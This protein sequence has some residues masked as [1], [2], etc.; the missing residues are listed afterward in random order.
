MTRLRGYVQV[1]LP[2]AVIVA[3]YVWACVAIYRYRADE[4]PADAIVLRFAHWQLE[5]GVRAAIDAA[6]RDYQRSVNPRVRVIQNIIPEST[7]AQWVSTQ[8]MGG[9]APDIINTGQHL[10]YYIWVMYY[11][12]YF[13][14][15]TTVAH[16]P[17]PYNRGTELSNMPLRLTYH[18]GMRVSYIDELQEYMTIPLSQ[19]IMRIFYNKDL[20]EQLTGRTTPPTEYRD[21]LNVC[22]RIRS[23][24]NAAGEHYIPIAASQYHYG[25]WETYMGDALTY[26]LLR[27]A[28]FNRDGTVGN[29]ELFAAFRAG[30]LTFDAAPLRARF[31]MVRDL[32]DNCQAGFTGVSRDE[33]VFLFAQQRAV[34]MTTGTWDVRS[35]QEQAAGKY[36]V[37]I[38]DYPIPTT[39]D[40]VFG[41]YIEGPV[42]DR[43]FTGVTPAIT[44]TCRHPEI[45]IDFL[46][47]LAGKAQNEKFNAVVGWIPAIINTRMN[48]ALRGF[49]PHME[50]VYGCLNFNLGGETWVKYSQAYSLFKVNQTDYAGFVNQFAPVYTNRGLRDFMELQRDWRRGIINNEQMLTAIRARALLATGAVARAGW[51]KY[52]AMTCARQIMPEVSHAEQMHLVLDVPAQRGSGPY[53]Y[54]SNVIARVRARVTRTTAA[55]PAP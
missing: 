54:S 49:E 1:G 26:P 19:F 36:R 40:P 43:S 48:D 6:A 28:D 55:E 32:C 38:M 51:I 16:R 23:Q 15:L 31:A 10:P 17:N 35:L 18:D 29:D 22:A 14:P 8:V 7:Y 41:P 44:R 46:L 47:F 25:M 42:F 21:F 45:A 9:T 13:I 39:N 11:N 33:A 50:G 24:T 30:L 3:T 20:L 27:K 2:I 12:R 4:M 37:G 52:R 53:E 5:P 34:F